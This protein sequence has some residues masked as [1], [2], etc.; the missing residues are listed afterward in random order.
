VLLKQALVMMKPQLI[1]IIKQAYHLKLLLVAHLPDLQ[2]SVFTSTLWNSYKE[3]GV[4]EME[5][6]FFYKKKSPCS[7]LNG[8]PPDHI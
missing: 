1:K 5:I 8:L 3:L 2:L 4:G 6:T 7:A